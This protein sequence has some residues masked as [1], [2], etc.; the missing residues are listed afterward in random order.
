MDLMNFKM[1]MVH[2]IQIALIMTSWRRFWICDSEG[3]IHNEFR[4]DVT[5]WVI[6]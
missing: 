2:H 4:S 1:L 3:G 6:W 5:C